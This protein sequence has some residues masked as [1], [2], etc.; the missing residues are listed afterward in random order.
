MSIAEARSAPTIPPVAPVVGGVTAVA[1]VVTA[2]TH[3]LLGVEYLTDACAEGAE[4]AD[5]CAFDATIGQCVPPP[6]LSS[7]ATAGAPGA[8]TPAPPASTVPT[9]QNIVSGQ[10][11]VTPSPATAWTEGQYIVTSDGVEGYWDG[12]KWVQGRAPAPPAPPATHAKAGAPG[13][14]FPDISTAPASVADL[15]A[16]VPNVIIALTSTGAAS[17]VTPWAAGQYIQTRT[18]GVAGQAHWSGT[19]WVAG[20]GTMFD[21]AAFTIEEVKEHVEGLANDAERVSKVQAILDMERAGK[22]RTTLVAWL[23]QQ[24]GVT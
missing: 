8:W 5:M 16:G 4:W 23:D 24:P 19:A 15:I 17:G 22:N 14:W 20:V 2:A 3:D 18:A 7:G 12:T 13:A 21:P 10:V 9:L 1:R 11:V 6:P